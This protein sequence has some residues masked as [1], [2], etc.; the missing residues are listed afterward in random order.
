MKRVVL[1]WCALALLSVGSTAQAQLF[2]RAK[3]PAYCPP[4]VCKPAAP[5]YCPPS[6]P[7]QVHPSSAKPVDPNSP[8]PPPPKDLP[9]SDAPMS[10]TAPVA[11]MDQTQDNTQQNNTQQQNNNLPDVPDQP[12]Q[13]QVNNNQN[14]N[15]PQSSQNLSA[16]TSSG[17]QNVAP[18]FIGDFFGGTAVYTVQLPGIGTTRPNAIAVRFQPS[19]TTQDINRRLFIADLAG[20][21]KLEFSPT[22][23]VAGVTRPVILRS[24]DTKAMLDGNWRDLP[25]VDTFLLEPS[26]TVFASRQPDGTTLYTTISGTLAVLAQANI[27]PNTGADRT[28]D[29]DVTAA[30]D[31][32]N[33][34]LFNLNGDLFDLPVYEVK[35]PVGALAGQIK[36]TENSSPLPQDR[37]IFNYSYFDQVAIRDG[38]VAVNR[39]VPGV[40]KTFWNGAMSFELKA[41]FATTMDSDIQLGAVPGGG[42]GALNTQATEFGNV[43]TTLKALLYQNCNFSVAAGLGISIPTADDTT[44][45]L[46]GGVDALKFANNATHFLPY[47]G[48]VFTPTP[49]FFAQAVMQLD[50]AGDD[51]NVYANLNPN[52]IDNTLGAGATRIDA[53]LQRVGTLD[54]PSF[55]YTDLNFGYWA[56]R[57]NCCNA[58]LT[59]VAGIFEIHYNAQLEDYDSIDAPL[60][61]TGGQRLVIAAPTRQQN[62][63][64]ILGSVIE[65]RKDTTI[66]MGYSLPVATDQQFDG[67]FRLNF[68]HYFGKSATR[69]TSGVRTPG[70]N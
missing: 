24:Q 61:G 68:N 66:S 41:P 42:F 34:D 29:G 25:G 17:A 38:G 67:E 58:A 19:D 37:I 26:Q 8:V 6:E 52:D 14:L 50:L 30:G 54:P 11:P 4:P 69:G 27:N 48:T 16:A 20:D 65:L 44:V 12:V 55:L 3:K 46:P 45:R 5:N 22:A 39:Y 32:Q 9:K 35:L 70:F 28:N 49:R 47:V 63:N 56:Y 62:V 31:P 40:E 43:Q 10:D 51:N 36:L 21:G 60:P 18:N 23:T 64:L 59:G 15:V 53:G 57:N 13:P 7:D 1:S 2:K 33:V